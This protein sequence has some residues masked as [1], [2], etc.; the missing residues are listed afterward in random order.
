MNRIIFICFFFFPIALFSQYIVKVDTSGNNFFIDER[1]PHPFSPVTAL[2]FSVPDTSKV[3]IEIHKV[4]TGVDSN[5]LMLTKPI[6]VILDSV[7]SKGQYY[8]DWDGKNKEGEK[9]NREDKYIYYLTIF[10]KVKTIYGIGYI[11]LEAKSKI[12]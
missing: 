2:Y 11:K 10:R 9:L 5:G 3:I 8:I 4:T 6:K 12:F 7:L 1:T